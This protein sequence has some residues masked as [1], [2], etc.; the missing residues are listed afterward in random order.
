MTHPA[1]PGQTPLNQPS[2][3]TRPHPAPPHRLDWHL[4]RPK[5]YRYQPILSR[6][7]SR[8]PYN[9]RRPFFSNL[10]HTG[11]ERP[12]TSDG[13]PR[14]R[15]SAPICGH[16]SPQRR[17]SQTHGVRQR[18]AAVLPDP[19][20]RQLTAARSNNTRRRRSQK[21]GSAKEM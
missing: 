6:L 7:M 13:N 9:R 17:R 15:S 10:P 16:S 11:G 8:H 2:H 3:P 4:P 14:R 1:P 12:P 21:Q 19:R 18:P 20:A 5:I